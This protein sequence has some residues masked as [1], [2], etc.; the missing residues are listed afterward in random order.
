MQPDGGAMR[1][2]RNE[3]SANKRQLCLRAAAIADDPPIV[4]RTQFAGKVK[5]KTSSACAQRERVGW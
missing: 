4:L 5:R 1:E 3:C 2:S